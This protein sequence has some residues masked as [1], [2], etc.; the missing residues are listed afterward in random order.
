MKD[1]TLY[2]SDGVCRLV[3]WNRSG[4]TVLYLEQL[5]DSTVVYKRTRDGIAERLVPVD[6]DSTVEVIKAVAVG[7]QVVRC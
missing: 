5:G 2:V 4:T 3:D 7:A 1:A 6:F